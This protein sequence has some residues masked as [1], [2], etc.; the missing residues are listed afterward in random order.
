MESKKFLQIVQE[1]AGLRD[2]NEAKQATWVVFDLLHHRITP[3][4]AD[5]VRAQLP[6]ELAEIWEGGEAWFN[7]LL[8]RFTPQNTFNRKE[9]IDQ[10][11]ARKQD[12][13]ATGE[14]ITRS[15]FYALQSQIS[16]GEADDVAAQLPKDLK[17][18]W[19][20]ARPLV[21]YTG[22]G[23]EMESSPDIGGE[24]TK[25]GVSEVWTN[26]S[27]TNPFSG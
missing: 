22:N 26:P 7:R 5:D 18:L 23:G 10:V 11:N 2:E 9:F 3:G 6:K 17:A 25:S 24:Y 12:L 13:P 15:V 16:P 27:V 8:A 21:Q 19:N 14:R 20:E 1:E 4:E